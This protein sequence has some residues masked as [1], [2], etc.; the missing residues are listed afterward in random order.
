MSTSQTS[1][2]QVKHIDHITLVV[3]DLDKSKQFYCDFLGMENVTRPGFNFSGLWFKA[4]NTLIHLILETDKTGERGVHNPER[5][6]S[7]RA[8][9]FAF[10]SENVKEAFE[11]LEKMGVP[12]LKQP[13]DR[14][15]GALQGFVN[16]PDGHVVELSEPV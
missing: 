5:N 3:N 7:T 10:L 1:P 15:D 4:G 16:D 11:Y 14:P 12:I 9:H 8:H 2:I 13:T 6:N